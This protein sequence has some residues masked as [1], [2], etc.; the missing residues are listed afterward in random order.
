MSGS[1]S[2]TF[3]DE[4][5]RYDRSFSSTPAYRRQDLTRHYRVDLP[6]PL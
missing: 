3:F 6:G 2:R 5:G 1:A 4:F